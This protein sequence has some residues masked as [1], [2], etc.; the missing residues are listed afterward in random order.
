MELAPDVNIMMTSD[1]DTCVYTLKIRNTG[2]EDMGDYTCVATNEHGEMREEVG[3]AGEGLHYVHQRPGLKTWHLVPLNT[4][5]ARISGT[6][7]VLSEMILLFANKLGE[8]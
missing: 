2:D 5:Q 7:R 8:L 3:V 1:V 4:K 6:R